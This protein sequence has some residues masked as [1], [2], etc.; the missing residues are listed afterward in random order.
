MW[1]AKRCQKCCVLHLDMGVKNVKKKTKRKHSPTVGLEPTTTRLRALRS[2]NWARRACCHVV[3]VHLIPLFFLS[4]QN[5]KLLNL[6]EKNRMMMF[7]FATFN[8]CYFFWLYFTFFFATNAI[9]EHELRQKIQ[10]CFIL[11]SRPSSH[12]EPKR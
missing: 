7:A 11:V 12:G 9:D 3:L 8:F 2:T 6:K 10:T 4:F 5:F 1:A